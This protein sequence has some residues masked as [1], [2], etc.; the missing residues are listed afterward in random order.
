L[1]GWKNGRNQAILDFH[2]PHPLECYRR[3]TFMMLDQDV[4]AVSPATV[5]RVLKAAGRL[6]RRWAAPSRKGTGFAQ[7]LHWCVQ[8]KRVSSDSTPRWTF[9]ASGGRLRL[10]NSAIS[11]CRPEPAASRFRGIP[12]ARMSFGVTRWRRS[13]GPETT[14]PLPEQGFRH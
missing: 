7:P 11:S 10:R 4:V 1:V 9:G 6:D 12:A 8:S 2:D 14:K 5:Y 3:L 13:F